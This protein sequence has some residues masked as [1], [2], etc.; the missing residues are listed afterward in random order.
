[1]THAWAA[2]GSDGGN[3]D[4]PVTVVLRSRYSQPAL[5]GTARADDVIV[6]CWVSTGNGKSC[7]V[8]QG[9]T[10]QLGGTDGCSCSS[11]TTIPSWPSGN[12]GGP[13]KQVNGPWLV[14][15]SR[16]TSRLVLLAWVPP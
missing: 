16:Q 4:A 9:E 1:M 6:V 12:H 8:T 5:N 7:W 3:P 14:L 13:T 11:K 10:W 2:A 15:E